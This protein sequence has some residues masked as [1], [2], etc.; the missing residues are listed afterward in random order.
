MFADGGLLAS[1]P[2]AASGAYINRMSDFCGA[3]AYDVK[4]KSGPRACPLNYLYWAFMIRNE[5][6]LRGNSRM[7]MPYRAL[8]AWSSERKAVVVKESEAFLD[9]LNY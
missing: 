7:A 6:A 2:Y 4:E 9:G 8:S 3:C 5:K 1:K